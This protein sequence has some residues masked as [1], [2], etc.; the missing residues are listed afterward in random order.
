MQVVLIDTFIV[1]E[2]A[3]ATFLERARGIQ[4]FIKTLPGFVEG[5]VYERK[6]GTSRYN[7]ITTAVWEDEAAIEAAQK[8]VAAEY[9]RQQFNPQA[10]RQQLQVE[11]ER[12]VYGRFPY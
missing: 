12:G 4:A 2:A 5:F 11:A 9:E 1:P 3:K 8:M 10:F 6:T 7:V